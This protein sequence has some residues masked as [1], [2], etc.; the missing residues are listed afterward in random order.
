LRVQFCHPERSGAES[1]DLTFQLVTSIKIK[2]QIAPTRIL[3]RDQ[4]VLP[5][6]SPPFQLFFAGDRATN[7][8][9][10]L[11]VDEIDTMILISEAR[12][13]SSAMLADAPFKIISNP[14]I[15]RRLRFIAQYVNPVGVV[16]RQD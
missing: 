8:S 3:F 12:D 4:C 15:E 1:K 5:L 9:E 13:F 7:I 14:D 11:K 16:G 10:L 2:R 6:P